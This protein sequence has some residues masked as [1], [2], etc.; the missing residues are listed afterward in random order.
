LLKLREAGLVETVK[1]YSDPR[2]L[3]VPTQ[4]AVT[5]LKSIGFQYV[6]ALPKDKRFKHY[7]HDIGLVELRIFALELGLGIWVPERVIRSIK[8]RGSSPDALLLTADQNYAIEYE[9]STKE[10]Y[11]RYKKIFDRYA[12]NKN[13]DGVL[14]ILPSDSRIKK[15]REK[16]GYIQKK[17]Y[18]ISEQE[19]FLKRENA[20]F[21]SS[22]DGLPLK[23]L[24][25][26]SRGGSVEDLEPEELK[27]IV[28][29][30]S[31]DAWKDRKPFI[32]WTGG[33]GKKKDDDGDWDGKEEN[34]SFVEPPVDPA[35]YG[36]ERDTNEED[37]MF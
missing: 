13:Y 8:P 4:A 37:K 3:Y 26:W 31:P 27:A 28:Q 30:E 33:G 10:P 5:L 7:E 16:V 15:L 34:S 22:S 24:I 9:L 25:Y 21:H 1:V 36:D 17:I 12:E 14:Y 29:S 6:P 23:Q 11:Q 2:D 20:V 18:F 32:P 19:L 35:M